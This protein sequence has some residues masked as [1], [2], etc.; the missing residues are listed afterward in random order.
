MGTTALT[1]DEGA[2]AL[3]SVVVAARAFE[4]VDHTAA[5][6]RGGRVHPAD[7]AGAAAVNAAGAGVARHTFVGSERETINA[8]VL[9]SGLASVAETTALALVALRRHPH[10]LTAGPLWHAAPL[11]SSW[12]PF[13]PVLPPW[14]RPHPT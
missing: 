2:P 13:L 6:A 12:R 11:P 10:P 14:P 4:G 8:D 3:A 5:A 1:L 9:I 7:G